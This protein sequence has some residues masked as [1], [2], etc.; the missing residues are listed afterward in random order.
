MH[1]GNPTRTLAARP[2]S[3][4]LKYAEHENALMTS[5]IRVLLVDDET[6]FL[7]VL[8]QCLQREGYEVRTAADVESALSLTAEEPPDVLVTD[9]MLRDQR[10][11]IDLTLAVRQRGIPCRSIIMSGYPSDELMHK[12]EDA[13][14]IEFISKPFSPDELVSILKRAG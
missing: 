9:W 3:P 11:G 12:L 5:P 8:G 2:G 14:Q 6:V 7:R 1:G 13:G 4:W 10:T